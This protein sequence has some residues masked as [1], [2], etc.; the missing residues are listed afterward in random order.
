VLVTILGMTFRYIF[1]I[2]QTAWDMMESRRS[3]AVGK[4]EASER[5]RIAAASAG[6]L[7]SRSLQLSNEVH[8]AMQSRGF[9]GE[10]YV[11]DDFR[12]RLS[13]WLWLFAFATTAAAVVV[14]PR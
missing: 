6:V 1:V 11:L 10:V 12:A 5:R 3:R 13:D 2:L 7:L 9:R 4:L 8:L 14:W